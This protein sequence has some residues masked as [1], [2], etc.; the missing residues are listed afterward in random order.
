MSEWIKCSDRMPPE[1]QM[2]LVMCDGDYDFGNIIGGVMKIFCMGDWKIIHN[3]EVTHWMSLPEPP[4][5]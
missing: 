4:A 2:V 3:A 5:E 1:C